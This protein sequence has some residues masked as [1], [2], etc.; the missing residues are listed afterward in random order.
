MNTDLRRF[1]P[2][3]LYLALFGLLA[4]AAL[5]IVQREM[6]I[7]LQ[8]SLALIPSG[9]AIFA[10]LDP[11]RV[12]QALTGRQ[13]RYGSNALVLT[14]AFVGILVVISYLA[15]NN[16][17]RW[18][19]TEDKEYT[20][21]PET[22]QT[23]QALPEPV[24]AQAFFTAT[25]G[26]D[27]ARALLEQYKLGSDGKFDYEFIDPIQNPIVAQQANITRD[28]TI[29]LVMGSQQEALTIASEQEITGGLVRL[30]NP[31]KRVIYFLT[32]HGEKSPDETGESG[33]SLVKRSLE[34]KNY[35]VKQLN[36]LAENAIPDDAKVVVIAG[37]Q[38]PLSQAEVDLLSAYMVG[39]GGMVALL[40]PA[41]LTKA[42]DAPDPLV[43][44]LAAAWGVALAQDIVVDPAS[45]QPSA[46]VGA[47][48]GSSPITNP[49]KGTASQFP[50]A[51]SARVGNIPDQSVSPLELVL[52]LD[53][54]WAETDTA[55]LQD[56]ATQ[57]VFDPTTDT[58]G[59]ISL[60][61]QAENFG[62]QARLVV[63]GDS[64]FP[65]DLNFTFMANG[66]LM[67]NSIDWTAGQDQLISLTPKSQT[68]RTLVP[69]QSLY[70]NLILLLIVIVLP[71][72]A[73]VAGIVVWVRRR[74]QG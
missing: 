69:P 11:E 23:L 49:I 62:S 63:F 10:L 22:L 64:D 38:Q 59:P 36:L 31:E 27:E 5:A 71:A 17:K 24:K 47:Q 20:L 40:E 14:L 42:G 19:L 8:I 41:V 16:P 68:S 53:Q 13:A 35:T 12:R 58:P 9:M 54:A 30:L 37:P 32:G 48:Y 57:I 6:T 4:S 1:A 52:T 73:L 25:A 50:T 33:Y 7:Y 65:I 28:G 43:D 39:G 15:V 56:P 74:R 60:A 46:P 18:D 26:P 51:R 67:I 21:T 44:Y 45:R 2:L 3:G 70:M 61:V 66:D 72:L 29:V 55:N 34:S